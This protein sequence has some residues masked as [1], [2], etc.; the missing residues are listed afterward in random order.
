MTMTNEE[1]IKVLK[2]ARNSF[3][4]DWEVLHIYDALDMAIE[5]LQ[6]EPKSCEIQGSDIISRQAAKEYFLEKA[7]YNKTKLMRMEQHRD[8]SYHDLT[9]R[10][11]NC[12]AEIED[13]E[14]FAKELDNVPFIYM[15]GV[16]RHER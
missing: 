8:E 16:C 6:T 15:Q 13:Y 10:I 1:A 2:L 9:D 14:F 12:K 7:N 11:E 3:N 5:A 4:G